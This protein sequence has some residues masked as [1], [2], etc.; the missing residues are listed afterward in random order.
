[1]ARRYVREEDLDDDVV[2]EDDTV[3]EEYGEE[4][5]HSGP[6]TIGAS[7]MSM[8][9]RLVAL[10]GLA[11]LALLSVRLAFEL[12]EANRA[13]N[14][15]EFIF[16]ITGPLVAPFQGIADVRTL[17]GGGVFDPAT[18]IAMGVY[19]LATALTMMLIGT[20]AGMLAASDE[21]PVVHRS[22][23]VRGH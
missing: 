3:V 11:V 8:L 13:N 5:V 12:G 6:A 21:G 1:M 20:I 2:Y 14:F 15:V 9:N 18:A 16:D 10:A 7:M 23:M 17:D 19:L 22:R 4:A